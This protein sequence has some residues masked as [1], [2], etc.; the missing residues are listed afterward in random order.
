MDGA[1]S[2]VALASEPTGDVTV[3]ISGHSGTDLSLDKNIL[4]FTADDWDSPQTVKVTAAHDDDAVDD[5]ET[6]THTASGADYDSVAKDLPVTIT[7]DAPATVTVSFG[8][9]TYTVVEGA[10]V[11]VTVD[12]DLDP[13]RQVTIPITATNEGGATNADYSGVLPT[14][15]FNSGDTSK[16]LTFTATQDTA[17]DDGERVKLA[18]GT[19]PSGVTAGTTSETVVSIT[20]DDLPATVTV[21]F[22]RSTYSATEG[23]D[24]AVVTVILGSPAKSQVE[25]PLTANGHGGAT[26]DDWSGV[27][28]TVI[29][30]K[31]DDAKSFT[32]TAVDDNVE[33]NGEMVE[34]GFG[35]LPTGFGPGSPGTARITLMNDDGIEPT[36]QNRVCTNGEITVGGQTDRWIWRITDSDYW[37]EYTIDLMGLHSNNGTLRDPHILYVTKIYTHDGFYPPAGS[38]SGGFPSYGSNDRGVGWDSS[39]QLRFR[40]K[41]GSFSYFPGKEPEL[42]TG[43]YTAL[44]GANPFGDGANGLGSYTLCIEGPGSISAVD[45]P[46]RRIVVSAAHVDVSDGEP[47]QFSIKLGARPTGPVEV[48]MTKLEPANDSQYV[49]EPLIHSFTGDNWDIP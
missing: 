11:T 17:D 15:T 27:P 41:K 20:D 34:L 45:Q 26:E 14:V 4:T 10:S 43:Y 35:T 37:D 30:D 31:G 16:T 6:L 46:E 42:D 36:G 39:S 29:F 9:A 28:E 19:L 1:P 21:R 3:T 40:N 38:A 7:D 18:F 49:V 5:P 32:V 33:D 23:G 24:D 48:F 2:M 25:I 44:V 8:A 22:E 12:L 47:A 13:E